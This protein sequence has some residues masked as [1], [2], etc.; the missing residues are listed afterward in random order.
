V[1]KNQKGAFMKQSKQS[2]QPKS[3]LCGEFAIKIV[4][5]P[6][7]KLLE[8]LNQAYSDEWIAYHQYWTCAKIVE[9]PMRA[10]IAK[11]MSEHAQEEYDHV[12][13]ITD[14]II[15]LGGKPLLSPMLWYKHKGCTY[16]ATKNSYVKAVLQENIKGEQCAIG[17]YNHMLELIENKDPLTYDMVLK[18]LEKEVEHEQDLTKLLN[19]FASLGV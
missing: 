18:I 19:E 11:E 17:F 5:F 9:G 3:K 12:T 10:L 8:M 16:D 7:P 15:Q 6:I 2:I 4:K 14:R 13:Q 1:V